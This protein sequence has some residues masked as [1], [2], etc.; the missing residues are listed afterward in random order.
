MPVEVVVLFCC[1]GCRRSINR[2]Q[3]MLAVVCAASLNPTLPSFM[4]ATHQE[5]A[6]IRCANSVHRYQGFLTLN[7]RLTKAVSDT[8]KELRQDDPEPSL[9]IRR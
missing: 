3:P 7:N 4:P 2:V 5:Y 8:R 9:P 1:S 6:V